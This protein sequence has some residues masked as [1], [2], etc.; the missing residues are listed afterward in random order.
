MLSEYVFVSVLEQWA[1]DCRGE[2]SDGVGR[3]CEVNLTF[4]GDV[5]ENLGTL[6]VAVCTS[7]YLRHPAL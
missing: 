1:R 6:I 4:G 7:H 5:R 3:S 2:G